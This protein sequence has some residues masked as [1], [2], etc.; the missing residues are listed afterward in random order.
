MY[1]SHALPKLR[2]SI[3]IY[4][5]PLCRE[6]TQFIDL[7]P[8]AELGCNAFLSVS[9]A[10]PSGTA[11]A[12]VLGFKNR[13]DCTPAA[14]EL[15]NVLVDTA[16]FHCGDIISTVFASMAALVAPPPYPG[17]PRSFLP[18]QEQPGGSGNEFDAPIKRSCA[19][20]DALEISNNNFTL[21]FK[22]HRIEAAF[23]AQYNTNLARMDLFGLLICSCGLL[24]SMF[25]PMG[26]F[27]L[28]ESAHV[29]VWRASFFLLPALLLLLNERTR[30]LYYAHRDCILIYY[31]TTTT[32][33]YRHVRNYID[34]VDAYTFKKLF[35][36][37]FVWLG[38]LILLFHA[39][40]QLLFPLVMACFACDCCL[41]PSI[42]ARYYSEMSFLQCAA[43]TVLRVGFCVLAGPL[44]TVW[45][46]E[47]RSRANFIKQIKRT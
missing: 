9:R 21:Q 10:L 4:S 28:D 39:R 7:K 33:W 23:A 1:H 42:C 27:N 32:L 18:Y 25:D 34:F 36:D 5:I 6:N 31:F 8:A 40:I 3:S 20:N 46:R 15:A 26:K 17:L 14:A 41:L 16:V 38:I 29:Q 35:V 45:W 22:D 19:S 11:I 2:A 13:S 44:A 24:A 43:S 47:R 12:V 30:A 37:G